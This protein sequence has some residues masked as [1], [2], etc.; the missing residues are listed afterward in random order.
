MPASIQKITVMKKIFALAASLI[1]VVVSASSQTE[2]KE[3][4][5]PPPPKV[6]VSKF[7]L[8]TDHWFYKQHPEVR[9]Y[10]WVVTSNKIIIHL[11]KNKKEEYNMENET[12]YS[13]FVSNYGGP[14]EFPPPPPPPKVKSKI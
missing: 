1:L 5:P 14:V 8:P 2:R 13:K 6:I 9:R 11:K 12:D 3:V 4:Q 10:T 7:T